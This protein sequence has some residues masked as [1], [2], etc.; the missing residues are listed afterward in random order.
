[1]P[2]HSEPGYVS[3]IAAGADFIEC[4]VHFTRCNK[5]HFVAHKA[6]V[7]FEIRDLVAVCTHDPWLDQLTDVGK[8]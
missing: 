5:Q 7:M 2:E 6:F 8:V 4:D 1:M 3:A